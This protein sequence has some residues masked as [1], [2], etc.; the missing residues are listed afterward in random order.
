MRNEHLKKKESL[1]E[2]L[3]QNQ[4]PFCLHLHL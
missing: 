4:V 3:S 2:P 1:S